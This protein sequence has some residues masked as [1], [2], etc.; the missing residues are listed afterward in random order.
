MKQFIVVIFLVFL[1][2]AGSIPLLAHCYEVG[3]KV[4][5]ENDNNIS[6]PIRVYERY[7]GN[8]ID[9]G[10]LN[11]SILSTFNFQ[12]DLTDDCPPYPPD[13]PVNCNIISLDVGTEYVIIFEYPVGEKS[14]CFLREVL[15]CDGSAD[16]Y[17]EIK[18][19]GYEFVAGG[20]CQ[21]YISGY[22]DCSVTLPLLVSL[23]I[24][25]ILYAGDKIDFR[26]RATATG[27][28]QNYTFSWS[29]ARTTSP[30]PSTNP[31]TA[32]KIIYSNQTVTVSVTVTSDGQSVT[33]YKILAEN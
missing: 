20:I 12:I 17:Y 6:I 22:P 5:D 8:R 33:K 27:G 4:M 23:V 29:I 28:D 18:P 19:D 16:T 21:E 10:N 15:E 7:G 13:C 31:N 9:N 14:L 11:S 25:D 30:T 26:L 3:F 32:H 2:I 24:Y 1:L